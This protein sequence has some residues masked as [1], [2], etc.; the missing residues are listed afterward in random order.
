MVDLSKSIEFAGLTVKNRFVMP[1]MVRNLATEEGIVTEAVVNQYE[2]CSKGQVGLIIVEAAA[3]TWDH[4]IMSKNIGI[5]DDKCIP[6]LR[7]LAD[8]INKHGAKS[9]IQINH[10]GL[11]GH[12]KPKFVG[13]SNVPV[14]KNTDPKPISVDEIEQVKQ[15]FVDAT[16]RAKEAGF[17]GVEIHGAHYYL[18]SAFLSSYTNRRNDEYGG[19]TKNKAKFSIDI[20]KMIREEIGDY[21]LIF[22]MNGFENVVDGVSMKEGIEIAKIVEQAG[23][24]CLHISCVVDS[25]F[26]PG[27]P[28]IF[29]KGAEPD[30]LKGYPYD[31]CIPV[32]GQIKPHVKIPVIGVGEV[33]NVT[34]VKKFQDDDICDMLG[35]GRG[36]LAD[37]Y[38]VQKV[39]EGRAEEIVPWKD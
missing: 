9:F 10:S 38:F 35:V 39:L 1:P 16:R 18:L 30:F 14:L 22:R 26:N 2:E 3:I 32:A 4:R 21:P 27:L 8:G 23:I 17:D 31:S 29:E 28:P 33:R 34:L 36:L 37:P 24:D 12:G 7:K 6:G 13:P 5:H 11:K 25:T 20:I 15:W 19:S